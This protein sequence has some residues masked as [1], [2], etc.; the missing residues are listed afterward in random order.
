MKKQY[1]TRLLVAISLIIGFS[2]SSN[3]QVSDT[4]QYPYWIEMM[5]DP[6]ANFL[7][8]QRAFEKY[9][10]NRE[11]TRGSGWKPFKRWEH[12]MF[13]RADADGNKPAPDRELKVYNELMESYSSRNMEG[14]WTPMGPFTVP[15]GYNGYRGLG[16]LNAIAFHPTD[17][18]HI[19][20]GA[21]S[22]GLWVTYDHGGAWQVLTD[23][24]PTL[25]VSSIIVDY[26][27]PSV[28]LIGTGDRDAADAPGLGVWRSTDGG[29]NWVQYNN[30]MGNV[31]VG[32]MEQDPN[33]PQIIIAATSGGMYRTDDGGATWERK[34]GGNF[35][36]VVL[37]PDNS[38]IVYAATGGTFYRSADNGNSYTI[39]NTGLPGANRGV[40]AVSPAEPEWVYFLLTN[41]DSFKGL[42]RSE[43][44]GLSFSV[45]ST[46]PNIMGWD[47]NGGSGGQAWYDLDV[48]ADPLDASVLYAGG[49]NC[50]KS[51]N[52]GTT[53]AIRSHWYGG[54]NVQSVH[55]DLHVLEYS[56]INN[57]L[58]AGN[59]GGFYWTENGGVNWT[60]IS[61]GLVISQAY[62]I[63]QSRTNPNYV[64]NGYQDNGT[65]VVNDGVWSAVGGGDGMECAY[66]PFDDKYIYYTLYYGSIY[67]AYNNY[68]NGQIA[69]NGVNGITESGAWVTPFFIDHEDGNIMF[70]GYKNVWR[71]TNIKANNTNQ[72]QWKKISAMGNSDMNVLVQSKANRDVVYASSGN[73]LYRT[74]NAKDE[75]VEWKTL[76]G[77]IPGSG[78]ITAIEC[79][80]TNPDIVYLAQQTAIFK[81]VDR[82]QSWTSINAG[83]S[84]TQINSI[85]YYVNSSEG[86]YLGTDI[87]VFYRDAS[88][89]D[90]VY[91][92]QGMPASAKVTEIEIYYDPE[93][94]AGDLLRA[95][96]YGRG[97]WSSPPYYGSVQA[98]MEVP[99]TE[100]AAGCFLDFYDTSTGVPHNWEWTFEGGEPAVSYDQH[101]KN[102]GYLTEGT[103]DVTLKV[104]NPLGSNTYV[105]ENCVTVLEAAPPLVDF[106]ASDTIGCAGLI[107][108]FTEN[109][110][111]CP[112]SWSWSFEPSSVSF[113]EGT[114][115]NSQHPVV[116]F[117]ENTAY[118]VEL[119]ATN[120]AGTSTEIRE[121]YI[122]LGGYPL[123]YAES[124]N[125]PSIEQTGWTVQN[126]D[127]KKGWELTSLDD[128]TNVAWMN[129]FNYTNLNERDYLVS[130]PLNL[131]NF[132]T[133]WL[134][135]EYAYA[136]RYMQVD[137]LI[138]SVSPDCGQSWERVYANG[139]DGNGIFETSEPIVQSFV[140]QS[141]ADWCYAGDYGA[142]CQ[143]IN[144]NQ[145][146][147]MGGVKIRFETF[148]SY[149]NNLYLKNVS[150]SHVTGLEKL[151][152]LKREWTVTPNPNKGSFE[153][154]RKDVTEAVDFEISDLQ[155]RLMRKMKLKA[156]EASIKIDKLP[157]GV[158]YI[159]LSNEESGALKV[160]VN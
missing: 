53:W 40:I 122:L 42:Y 9:W 97:L 142:D 84:G 1:Y 20:V 60:E 18:N 112:N 116:Q 39:V 87:G 52:G 86:L 155:G 150:V 105:Y 128:G 125:A 106:V 92:R 153:L 127:D 74:D 31:T 55:A 30:G 143:L 21:P 99:V 109:S 56:P 130:P 135:F 117:Q 50:F 111:N 15:S 77:N 43:D 137:S 47:C 144:L 85:A 76:T 100:V 147:G 104:S 113:L 45:R 35:K 123:P 91:F 136:Q 59:D 44:A 118:T 51:T 158:Y 41:S 101:P 66:D 24:L 133:V 65:S 49:V 154:Q 83:L 93:G 26:S 131:E 68:D 67:R 37:K 71:S 29:V 72:V 48:A 32:R 102:I 36:E 12:M 64:I 34:Q 149:G 94:P 140:P 90:W 6:D 79:H 120:P 81:S 134:Y 108:H 25:G 119:T 38:D 78:T 22:G 7:E 13:Q 16:R 10:E 148:N 138:I 159:I 17:P 8:T 46:S 82:G 14:N 73:R 63:G 75:T 110:S 126:P 4:A 58:Y 145:Y 114:N 107:V 156:G 33:D 19:Y 139:P 89:D 98:S 27:N 57:R 23:H 28:I 151:S 3:A 69:G 95:G 157:K 2:F 70:V 115:A 88:M 152:N 160:I 124:F 103:Y 54:C 132:E 96:T 121:D 146:A 5:K 61:N 129:F 62:K 141:D 11:V 80:P